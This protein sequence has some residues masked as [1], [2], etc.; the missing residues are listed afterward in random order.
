MRNLEEVRTGR[1]VR[2]WIP[3]RP[4]TAVDSGIRGTSP[5]NE[6]GVEIS[7]QEGWVRG[8]GQG[9]EENIQNLAR[10]FHG[11]G[12]HADESVSNKVLTVSNGETWRTRLRSS[13][14]GYRG[15]KT[16]AAGKYERGKCRKKYFNGSPL[17]GELPYLPVSLLTICRL[18][19]FG[20]ILAPSCRESLIANLD[21]AV[22]WG[23]TTLIEASDLE[24]YCAKTPSRLP[25]SKFWDFPR[26]ESEESCCPERRLC[27]VRLPG[28]VL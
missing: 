24:Y 26:R 5:R 21:L 15:R 7:G 10:L 2:A 1:R 28:R 27:K 18:Y 19:L 13:T 9:W 12:R 4:E 6:S 11:R 17:P 25:I 14:A 20:A 23:S 16:A 22:Q 3:P 8:G